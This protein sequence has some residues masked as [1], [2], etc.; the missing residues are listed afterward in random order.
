M[1]KLSSQRQ[2]GDGLRGARLNVVSL[3]QD[4]RLTEAILEFLEQT[5]IGR[6]YE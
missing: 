1:Q 6:R 5:E 2:M 3:F 4:E